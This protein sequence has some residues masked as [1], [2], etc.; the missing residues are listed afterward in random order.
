MAEGAITKVTISDPDISGRIDALHVQKVKTSNDAVVKEWRLVNYQ[1]TGDIDLKNGEFYLKVFP[2]Y[3]NIDPLPVW[4]TV[5]NNGTKSLITQCI[6]TER[7][8]GF[9]NIKRLR[10]GEEMD[11]AGCYRLEY[12]VVRFSVG[13]LGVQVVDGIGRKRRDK[14]VSM[15]IMKVSDLCGKEALDLS[16]VTGISVMRLAEYIRK[17]EIACE[18]KVSEEDYES[19]GEET[20][21]ELLN[22]PVG[23]LVKRTG[24]TKT[25]IEELM[26][27][28]GEITIVIDATY[29]RNL[30][31]NTFFE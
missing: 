18:I 29:M 13:N 1:S 24:R 8:Q 15:G 23:D 14:L 26:D 16:K 9:K 27:T 31:L 12:R 2:Y 28:I 6:T 11:I 21:I 3:I 25:E 30:S 7:R 20:I 17:A 22:T 4:F 5:K 10:S 19:I